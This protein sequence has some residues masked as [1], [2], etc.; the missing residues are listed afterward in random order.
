MVVH[1]CEL[2]ERSPQP[3][4]AV[5]TRASVQELP[6]MMGRIYGA[7]MDAMDH[8]GAVMAGEPYTAYFNMD[9]A[10]LDLEIGIPVDRPVDG[11]DDVQA[12]EIPG[13]RFASLVHVG[14]YDQ[15]ASAYEVLTA[16]IA[17]QGLEVTGA[18]Y[19]FYFSPPETP[20]EQIKTEIMLPVGG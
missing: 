1:D 13:G 19:E 5:R 10:D 15:L 17:E 12:V 11:R 2:R 6:E 14:P 4:L 9:V 3:A 20:P 8:E 7:I 18:A 16:W